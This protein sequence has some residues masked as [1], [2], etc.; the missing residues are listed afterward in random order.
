MR[1]CASKERLEEIALQLRKDILV[2][3]KEAGSG[4]PGG[5]LSIVEMLTALYF[6]EMNLDPARPDWEERDRFVLSKGHA[7]PA[8]YAALARRGYFDPLELKTLRKAGSML[9]GHPDMR[10]TPGVDASTGSLGQGISIACGMALYAKARKKA[11]RVFCILGDGELQE[12]QVWEALMSAAHRKLAGLTA[13][14]DCNGLQIDGPV[15][16]VMGLS[17]LRDKLEA[18]G[19]KTFCCDGHDIGQILEVLALCREETERPCA[20]LCSTIKGKGVSFMENQVGWHGAPLSE[21]QFEQAM[22]ELSCAG[23][24]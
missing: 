5:S 19:W 1:E 22:Q 14:I 13:L 18:F 17:P 9:Q 24:E 20:V 16:E 8:Y 7:A 21:E 23:A 10:K 2:E 12:G 15:S 4:H 11:F 3:L 6:Y